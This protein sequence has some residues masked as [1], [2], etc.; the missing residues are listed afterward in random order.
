MNDTADPAHAH[1]AARARWLVG[2]GP[3]T[4]RADTVTRADALVARLVA[5]GRMADEAT[6]Y[7]LLAAADRLT[8]TA[9]NVVAHMTYARRIDLSGAPLAADDFKPTPEGHTGGALN[10]V[11]AYV[12]Y[13]LANALSGHT[14][15][16]IMGQGHCV[17]AI[18]AVNALTG[19]VSPAQ[20]GR[21]DRSAAGLSREIWATS[22]PRR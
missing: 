11:Q 21:Y 9:M 15:G 20:R 16:W 19:V 12:G 7:A 4:H 2:H 1:D 10:M 3:I 17:A 14:R 18:V 8:C 13:L 5:D 22:A 6:A